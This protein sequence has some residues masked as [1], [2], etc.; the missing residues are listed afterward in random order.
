MAETK[1]KTNTSLRTPKPKKLG[2]SVPPALRLPHE[3][4]I[5]AESNE[6][7][8]DVLSLVRLPDESTPTQPSHTTT[9]SD[10]GMSGLP[11]HTTQPRHSLDSVDRA[12]LE[13]KDR[14]ESAW[15]RS[16]GITTTGHTSHTT[17][18]GLPGMSTLPS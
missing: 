8:K 2:L 3:D 14:D 1:P 16:A 7:N 18:T 17:Q 12:N 10:P 5:M 13:E 11:R 9:A 6:E 15:A 4:L